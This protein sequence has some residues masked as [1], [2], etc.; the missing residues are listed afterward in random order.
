MQSLL[1]SQSPAR[2]A[3][4][5]PTAKED[6]AMTLSTLTLEKLDA[7]GA[8]HNEPRTLHVEQDQA[9][10]DLHLESA[11]ALSCAL[12]QLR[13][14]TP[15]SGAAGSEQRAKRICRRLNYLLEP[16]ELVEVDPDTDRVLLR[17][18]PPH[19]EQSARTYY[20]VIVDPRGTVTLQRFC[21]SRDRARRAVVACRLTKEATAKLIDD[22]VESMS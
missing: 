15:Q 9:T 6:R 7:L 19:R 14:E 22:L 4:T 21:R 17:S 20:E 5:T 11:D 8:F 10:L 18:N 3:A 2:P 16:L 13:L 1:V 12:T